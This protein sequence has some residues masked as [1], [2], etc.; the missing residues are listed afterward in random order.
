M[1]MKRN[2]SQRDHWERVHGAVNPSS[3]G[4]SQ[5]VPRL[6]LA[7]I[8]GLGLAPES[9]IIDVGGG[10]SRLVDHL[11]ARS[12]IQVT[13][14]D[15]SESALETSRTRI[16]ATGDTVNWIHCDVLDVD[17]EGHFDLWHD[18]AV[19]H[20]LTDAAARERYAG[21]L[22]KALGDGGHA[23]IATF[24]EDGPEK[25]SGLPVVRYSPAE[26]HRQLGTDHFDLIE[27]RREVHN[28]PSGV[29][30]R[31]QYSVLSKK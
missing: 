15:L 4:W 2:S 3:V 19:F 8:D 26:L 16:G 20:F 23:V 13:V 21:C 14:L 27:E 7:L 25:C 1:T 24:A 18:R 22:Y 6:S 30:Q 9:H 10:T 11:L 28:T 29:E 31:F 12:D 17:L 5:E